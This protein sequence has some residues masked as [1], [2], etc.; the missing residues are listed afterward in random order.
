MDR[1][2]GEKS[3]NPVT[4]EID[5]WGSKAGD[6]KEKVPD[7]QQQEEQDVV[8]DVTIDDTTIEDSAD[9]N[10]SDVDEEEVVDDS[11]YILPQSNVQKLTRVPS[12]YLQFSTYYSVKEIFL[13]E[14]CTI[15]TTWV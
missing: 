7:T 15:L 9:E 12:R 14:I 2:F 10:A 4:F 5:F 11:E 8:E 3:Y 1:L 13:K 6:D